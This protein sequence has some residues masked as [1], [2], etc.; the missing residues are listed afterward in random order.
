M[1]CLHQKEVINWKYSKSGSIYPKGNNVS[2][3]TCTTTSK[4]N[5]HELYLRFLG[6]GK[7]TWSRHNLTSNLMQ[8]TLPFLHVL[9][10][11]IFVIF[12]IIKQFQLSIHSKMSFKTNQDSGQ[13]QLVQ[14][15]FCG[16]A[17][18][19]IEQCGTE[20]SAKLSFPKNCRIIA[21]SRRL[22]LLSCCFSERCLSL[23]P[24]VPGL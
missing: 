10:I 6:L 4:S 24:R 11:H 9:L 23:V 3:K 2:L 18:K 1:D 8:F 14:K 15:I 16:G 19:L 12:L 7:R 5:N 17:N 22:W 20:C 21:L 13:W